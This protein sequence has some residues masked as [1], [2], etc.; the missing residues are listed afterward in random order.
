MTF[1][2]SVLI[3]GVGPRTGTFIADKFV[4]AGYQVAATGRNVEDGPLSD[5]YLNIKADLTNPAVVPG[6]FAKVK[7]HFGTPPNVVMYNSTR[8]NIPSETLKLFPPSDP[9]SSLES[10]SPIS[11]R[12]TG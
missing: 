7:A 9:E 3:F 2:P 6:V 5:G 1:K 4:G 8:S 11:R 10:P 12:P